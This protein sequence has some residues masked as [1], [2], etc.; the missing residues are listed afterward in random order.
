MFKEID[1]IALQI[2]S[3][4]KTG[5]AVRELVDFVFAVHG[6]NGLDGQAVPAF[7]DRI[8]GAQTSGVT[9]A[10]NRVVEAIN[11]LMD[12]FSA[13]DY[14]QTSILQARVLRSAAISLMPNLFSNKD[15]SGAAWLGS[16]PFSEM[17][18]CEALVLVLFMVQQKTSN[19][20]FLKPPAEWDSELIAKR[21]TEASRN[22][23]SK[24]Y[25]RLTSPPPS[26]ALAE[27]KR[28]VYGTV[29]SS[30]ELVSLARGVLDRLGITG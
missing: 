14:A 9:V 13:P 5:Q 30:A 21:T 29:R 6:I 27:M 8:A 12:Q 22:A 24:Q 26:P 10:E 11:W 28:L 18:P 17:S 23:P 15:G 25:S 7:R 16:E 20:Q 4:D 19:R 3:G 2:K 1:N